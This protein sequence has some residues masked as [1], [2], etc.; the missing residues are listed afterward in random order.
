MN[1]R[2]NQG[3]FPPAP[4]IDVTFITAVE[5]LSVGPLPG[6]VDGGADGTMCLSSI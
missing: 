6:F 2:Y 4:F 5:S 3:Y 1:Y